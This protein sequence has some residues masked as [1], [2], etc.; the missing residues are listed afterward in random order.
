M[1]HVQLQVRPRRVRC[2]DAC[3][4]PPFRFAVGAPAAP[5]ERTAGQ[6]IAAAPLRALS[7]ALGAAGRL[8]DAAFFLVVLT[9]WCA[10]HLTVWS[11]AF[12]MGPAASCFGLPCPAWLTSKV[13]IAC[14]ALAV[15][16]YV[17]ARMFRKLGHRATSGVL[18]LLVT[19][20]VAALIVLGVGSMT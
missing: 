10:L 6:R 7:L 13:V 18:L 11:Y 12:E 1:S 8:V 5:R 3:E 9:I 14:I 19:F 16:S 15:A 17:L 2:T 4:P 20:D